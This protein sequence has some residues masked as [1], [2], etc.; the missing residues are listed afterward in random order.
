MADEGKKTKEYFASLEMTEE[1]RQRLLDLPRTADASPK[2][3]PA[4]QGWKP[5]AVAAALALVCLAGIPLLRAPQTV[6]PKPPVTTRAPLPTRTV[7][8]PG[9]D[10]PE[11]GTSPAETALPTAPPVTE[12]QPIFPVESTADTAPPLPTDPTDPSEPTA[13]TVAPAPTEPT[14]PATEPIQPATEPTEPS[15]PITEPTE[16]VTEPPEPVTEPSEPIT[17]PTEFIPEPP[18]GGVEDEEI[19]AG[20]LGWTWEVLRGAEGDQLRITDAAGQVCVL[21]LTGLL[22][23]GEVCGTYRIFGQERSIRL[24]ASWDGTWLLYVLE[25]P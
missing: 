24:C 23:Y 13:P 15:Q 22:E 7:P 2:A 20:D 18:P 12:T 19:P 3:R 8:E 17:E 9:A 16:P 5:L 11:P 10:G 1:F 4:R 6:S 14:Q 21:D 25:E